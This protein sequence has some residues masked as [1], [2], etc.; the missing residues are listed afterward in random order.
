MQQSNRILYLSEYLKLNLTRSQQ[1]FMAQIRSGTLPLELEIGRYVGKE[2]E[3]RM[4]PICAGDIET[5]YHFLFDCNY[6]NDER[7]DFYHMAQVDLS[8][9]KHEK[10]IFLQESHP[11]LLSKFIQRIYKKRQDFLF[12]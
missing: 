5:E 7:E 4:C 3:D 2:R 11:R 10:F 12:T 9:S 1:S 8:F 6:F